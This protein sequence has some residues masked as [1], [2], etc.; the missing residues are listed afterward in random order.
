MS[1]EEL[2]LEAEQLLSQREPSDK[3]IEPITT[4]RDGIGARETIL[5]SCEP[6]RPAT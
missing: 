3:I 4:T 1:G 6:D 2:M 5:E